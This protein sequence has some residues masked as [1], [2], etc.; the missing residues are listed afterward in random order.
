MTVIFSEKK[1]PISLIP[2]PMITICPETKALKEK[3]DVAA[4]FRSSNGT[5]K[6]LTDIE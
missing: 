5:K 3:L 6:K 4:M 2:F 1:T